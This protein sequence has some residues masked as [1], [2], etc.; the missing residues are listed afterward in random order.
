[1]FKISKVI[2]T[3]V[4]AEREEGC[5]EEEVAVLL[6]AE[7]EGAGFPAKARSFLKAVGVFLA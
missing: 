5:E 1:M 2:K 3:E 7:K 4:V 6:K